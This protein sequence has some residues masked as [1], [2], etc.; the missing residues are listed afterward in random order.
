MTTQSVSR[1]KEIFLEKLD[2]G[3]AVV[4]IDSGGKYNSLGSETIIELGK[5]LDEIESDDSIKAVVGTSAKADSFIIGA[6]LYEIRKSNREELLSLSRSGQ[7]LL[8]RI[9]T[10]KKPFLVA[11]NG[12]CLGGGLEIALACHYR[13]CS[14]SAKSILGLPETRLGLIP[15][16]GGTQRL[17]RL[18]GLKA[19]LDM[20]LSA[21]TISCQKGL[22]L[23]IL[24]ELVDEQE[25]LQKAQIKALELIDS[26]E[27]R[28][29]SAESCEEQAL[30]A[31]K[32]CLHEMTAEKSEKVLSVSERAVKLRT[33][34][35]YP[36]Q[37]EAIKVIRIGLN[38]GMQAGLV[39][40]A[41][42]FAELAGGEV[43]A[44]LISLFFASDLAKSSSQ[45]LVQ[46]HPEA[47]LQTLGIIGAGTMGSSLAEMAALS[48]VKTIVKTSP[49]RLASVNEKIYELLQRN[50]RRAEE[51][52]NEEI[53]ELVT[54]SSNSEKLADADLVIECIVEDAAL[55]TK[56]L[57][58]TS[59]FLKDDAVIASNTSALSISELSKSHRAA[60]NF[61]GVHFFH[62]IEKMPLVELIAHAGTSKRALAKACDLVLKLDKI[63][64]LVKDK[65]GFLINRI[66][67]VYLFELARLAEEKT[68]INW[69]EDTM[70]EF[71]MPMGPLQ[72]MDEIGIDVAFTVARNLEAGLGA[73][74][75]SPAIFKKVSAIGMQGKRSNVGF[76]LWENSEKKVKI[77]PDMLEKTGALVNSEKCPDSE[78]QRISDRMILCMLDEAC[79]CLEERIVAKA[80]EIDFALILG[81]GFPAFRGGLFKYADSRGLPL[82][83]EELESIYEISKKSG[84]S[85]ERSVSPLLK[86]YAQEGRGFYSLNKKESD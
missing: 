31:G 66:L 29:A 55:K 6:D 79:R 85:G 14:N 48:G 33:K 36:A 38:K 15:G 58:E 77:N 45:A 28:S 74:L 42:A 69:I 1:K 44:H 86:K 80:R 60:E 24:D 62:P 63:P 3:V 54:V 59:A 21:S 83:V 51:K 35:H 23:G 22:E 52:T 57:Q 81:V 47:C 84:S 32:F 16:L 72:L 4:S 27:L 41:E 34:G 61:L 46:K 20:I 2:S 11:I 5:A 7:K 68:P 9:A 50:K 25:L 12:T 67:T 26:P 39:A 30:R 43:S 70:I 13:I 53:F 49:E 10:F 19:A 65:P 64:L 37:I 76:Y 8:D 73:R 40:E 82:I 17:P 75:Q 71:G 78:K 56:V 18:I